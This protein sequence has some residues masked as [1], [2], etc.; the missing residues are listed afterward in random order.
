MLNALKH[1]WRVLR[2]SFFRRMFLQRESETSVIDAFAR[3]YFDSRV[4]GNTYWLGT[5]V[6]KCPLDLWIY[7]ELI[8]SLRPDKIIE[9]GTA[10]GGS[11]LFMASMCDLIDNGQILSIDIVETPGRPTH[12]RI[13]YFEGSSTSGS[14]VSRVRSSIQDGDKVMVVLDSDHS[15]LH[16]LDELRIYSNIVTKGSYLVVE[17][18]VINGHP[19]FPSF[20]PGPMEAVEEFLMQTQDFTVDREMEK[21]LLTFNPRGYLRK[22]R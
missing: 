16:V 2:N 14:V 1:E 13:T 19:A 4:D 15:K 20:G 12:S 5:P 18:T 21:H 7:Q 10:Y 22:Q 8:I 11:A 9:C 3:L 6:F 17:D